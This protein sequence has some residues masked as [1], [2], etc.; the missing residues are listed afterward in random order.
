MSQSNTKQKGLN[1]IYW[2][3]ILTTAYF[4]AYTVSLSTL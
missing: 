2:S 4:L 1:Y 3:V